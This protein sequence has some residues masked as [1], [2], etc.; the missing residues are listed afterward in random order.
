MRTSKPRLS[1]ARSRR[2]RKALS[3]STSNRL[4]S[5]ASRSSTVLIVVHVST[6]SQKVKAPSGF[7]CP[8][9]PADPH[10]RAA[11]CEVLEGEPGAGALQQRLG[12]EDAESQPAAEIG[13]AS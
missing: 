1:I 9:R 2:V 6:C 4:R 7:D 3:S 10:H 11:A 13:R 5:A 12:D 8:A